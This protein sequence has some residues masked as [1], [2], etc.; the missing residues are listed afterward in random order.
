M[1]DFWLDPSSTSILHVYEQWRLWGDRTDVQASLKS[2]L[3]AYVISTKISWTGSILSVSVN[4]CYHTV[5]NELEHVKT[6]KI[7]C[8]DYGLHICTVWSES[9]HSTV[10][11]PKDQKLLQSE[12]GGG[13]I[14]ATSWE[15]LFL[16][17]ANNKDADQP[18]RIHTV[19]SACL[20]FTA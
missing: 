9:S 16:S 14:W 7:T 10:W 5:W 15:N 8:E 1:S 12:W 11:V 4:S 19:W 6:N 17:Y 18:L 3:V 13:M 20:L 2:L